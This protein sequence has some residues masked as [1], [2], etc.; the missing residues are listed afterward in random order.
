MT[1]DRTHEPDAEGVDEPAF[2]DQVIEAD[3]SGAFEL[4]SVDAGEQPLTEIAL[5]QEYQSRGELEPHRLA[6]LRECQQLRGAG[7]RDELHCG[8]RERRR[9]EMGAGYAA[10]DDDN[11]SV[12]GQDAP[13]QPPLHEADRAA[14]RTTCWAELMMTV[15]GC[16]EQRIRIKYRKCV[17]RRRGVSALFLEHPLRSNLELLRCRCC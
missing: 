8:L 6:E 16:V 4:F 12:V 1:N 9:L 5:M 11:V 10:V 15:P 7:G 17:V 3:V 2:V 13:D 14:L